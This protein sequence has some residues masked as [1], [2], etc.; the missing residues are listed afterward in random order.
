VA[1]VS[2]YFFP[3]HQRVKGCSDEFSS[4]VQLLAGVSLFFFEDMTDNLQ[5]KHSQPKNLLS[6]CIRELR[7]IF[8][9]SRDGNLLMLNPVKFMMLPIHR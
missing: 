8:K 7:K 1:L 3:R 2:S 9:W 4:L 5:I 6:E